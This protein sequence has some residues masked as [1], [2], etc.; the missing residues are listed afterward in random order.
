L[1]R[2]KARIILL[3]FCS[4]LLVTVQL[5]TTKISAS[6]FVEGDTREKPRRPNAV[7]R[8]SLSL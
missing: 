2:A 3:A 5:L 6:D 7:A 8:A 1:E 4:A